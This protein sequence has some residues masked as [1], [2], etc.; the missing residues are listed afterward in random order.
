MSNI[1]KQLEQ[2]Q[3]EQELREQ[4]ERELDA[5]YTNINKFLN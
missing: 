3:L 1:I 2:E 4:R 5:Y